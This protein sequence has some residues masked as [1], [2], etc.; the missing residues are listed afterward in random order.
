M[1]RKN[2]SEDWRPEWEQQKRE[3]DAM[4]L[5]QGPGQPCPSGW[6]DDYIIW[7]R[8]QTGIPAQIPHEHRQVDLQTGHRSVCPYGKGRDN[9]WE[10]DWQRQ[11]DEAWL[12]ESQ[13]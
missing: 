4:I 9:P 10:A 12:R 7:A 3:E 6:P 1:R 13:N 11:A 5:Q 2:T 8:C